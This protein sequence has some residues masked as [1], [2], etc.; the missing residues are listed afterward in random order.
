M[1]SSG[2]HCQPALSE[3]W[4]W[5]PFLSLWHLRPADS[6]WPC[7][8][9]G[10]SR[11]GHYRSNLG[12]PPEASLLCPLPLEHRGLTLGARWEPQDWGRE[13]GHPARGPLCRAKKSFASLCVCCLWRCKAYPLKCRLGGISPVRTAPSSQDRSLLCHPGPPLPQP[14]TLSVNLPLPPLPFPG[15]QLP[16]G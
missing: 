10:R 3:G 5:C 2:G 13:L 6:R 1:G 9:R 4:A 14:P 12:R 7:A 16:S 11:G 8:Q 15:T